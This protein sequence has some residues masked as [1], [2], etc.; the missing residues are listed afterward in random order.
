[1]INLVS[2]F[3]LLI[4]AMSIAGKRIAYRCTFFWGEKPLLLP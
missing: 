2:G 3:T 1:L 4:L